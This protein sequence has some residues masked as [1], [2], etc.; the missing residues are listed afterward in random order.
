MV[1]ALIGA[2]VLFASVQFND[3]IP[4]I[5][6]VRKALGPLM[7]LISL[8]FLG[9]VGLPIAPG[10]RVS[11]WLEDR[12]A[13]N[14]V[15]GAFAL[16]VAFSLAFCPT[17]FLLFFGLL[18]PLALTQPLG[19][20]Y[21]ALFAFGTVVPLLVLAWY[22]HVGVASVGDAVNWARKLDRGIRWIA[23]GVL[24]LTGLNDTFVYWFV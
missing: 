5:Q 7:L 6:T 20:V 24:L 3:Y 11:A 10:Q 9:L 1:Y 4:V 17:L 8:H 13:G 14:D 16:G 15:R 18:L 12:F 23:A 21:P 22:L 2:A 19:V